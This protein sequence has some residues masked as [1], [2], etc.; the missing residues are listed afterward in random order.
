MTDDLLKKARD[1]ER[2]T[3]DRIDSSAEQTEHR[4]RFHFASPAGWINDPNGFSSFGGEFHLF[5]Q[6]HPYSAQWG[7]MHWGHAVTRDF[8][9]WQ[10]KGAAL[11]PDTDADK[12][13]CFSGTAIDDE[14]THVIAYTGV[15][16]EGGEEL[17]QQCLAA[18][19]S[20]TYRKYGRNPVITA[21]DVPFP[22]QRNHFRDPKIWKEG[23]AYFLAAALKQ[24]DGR[25]AL[26]LFSSSDLHAW[27]F[28]SVMDESTGISGMWECPDFFRLDGTDVIIVSPQEMKADGSR[29]FHDGNNS[30][31]MAGALNRATFRFERKSLPENGFTAAQIDGGTDF[32]APQ[33]APSPDG[34]RIMIAWMQS[35]ESPVTPEHLLWSGM[36]TFPR[37]LRIKNGRLLQSP[38]REIE[39]Y[40]T[41]PRRRTLSFSGGGRTEQGFGGIRGRHL[42]IGLRIMPP[43]GRTGSISFQFA[44]SGGRYAELKYDAGRGTLTFDRSRTLNPGALP[45][46]S[47]NVQAEDGA[48][49]L[50]ILLDTSSIE[51]FANG[52][53]SA[54]TG[55]F[56]MPRDAQD[57]AVAA[58]AGFSVECICFDIEA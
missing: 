4:P 9:R 5:F 45:L 31:Y 24:M 40:R 38:V 11:A 6:H 29:G 3:A 2:R 19:S 41:N 15:V 42:D 35:W 10:N 39:Q 18:G 58:D 53:K 1:C 25:G 26:A 56:F 12:G 16:K 55:V 22:F 30:V 37:E 17:Q 52:G 7:S 51:A 32:Y 57:I 13:G 47:M 27:K 23:G 34:R 28:V 44:K 14:G 20:G 33:T 54:L 36:M 50:R 48:L 49:S 46:R 21:A 8:V 43:A